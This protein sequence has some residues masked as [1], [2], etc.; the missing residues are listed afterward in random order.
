[1]TWFIMVLA[2]VF[3]QVCPPDSL[4]GWR[5]SLDTKA[6]YVCQ[7]FEKDDYVLYHEF[8]HWIYF[9]KL[10]NEERSMWNLL[11]T[12]YPYVTAYASKIA[13]EDRAEEGRVYFQKI[14]S[15]NTIKRSFVRRMMK[16]YWF[17]QTTVK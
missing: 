4:T 1:M 14:K 8:S 12:K 10:S 11:S 17:D 7:N 13:E 3:Y 15:K 5:Y 6:I 2:M 9:N 16:K